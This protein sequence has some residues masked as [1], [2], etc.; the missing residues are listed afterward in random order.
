[1]NALTLKVVSDVLSGWLVKSPIVDIRTSKGCLYLVFKKAHKIRTAAFCMHPQAIFIQKNVPKSTEKDNLYQY[2]KSHLIGSTVT[3]VKTALPD[4]VLVIGMEK[5]VGIRKFKYKIIF[6]YLGRNPNIIVVDDADTVLYALKITPRS[7]ESVR[8]V[9]SG[10]KWPPPIKQYKLPIWNI[11][12]DFLEDNLNIEEIMKNYCGIDKRTAEMIIENGAEKFFE[13]KKQFLNKNFMPKIVY[14]KNRE[15]LFPFRTDMKQKSRIFADFTALFDYLYVQKTENKKM[16][17]KRENLN[18]I[19]IKELSRLNKKL[20]NASGEMKEAKGWKKYEDCAVL[21][22]S[23]LYRLN[24][25]A[26]TSLLKFPDEPSGESIKISPELTITENMH[27]LFNQSKKF[28]RT[29]AIKK[30]I[31]DKI[32][33]D[34]KVLMQIDYDLKRSNTEEGLLSVEDELLQA[35]IIKEKKAK[36]RIKTI[37]ADNIIKKQLNDA[38]VIYIGKNAKGN[39]KIT[40]DLAGK[41]DLWFHAKDV[42]GSHIL[43]KGSYSEKELKYAAYTAAINSKASKNKKVDVDYTLKKFI[44]KPKGAKLGM[45]IYKNYK[46][47]TIMTDEIWNC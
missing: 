35:G 12:S 44:K 21:I 18:K 10:K 27:R 3:D 34:I 36:R 42:P 6:E 1:M 24:G 23:N 31:I 16:D 7:V 26:H 38:A 9:R 46:T 41:D 14:F 47:I 8:P 30:G 33:G 45:V 40:F 13:V 5:I 37:R 11:K 29:L 17:I 4:K 22:K 32:N 2:A 19:I 43:L 20:Q 25:N 39:E 28:K 15:I